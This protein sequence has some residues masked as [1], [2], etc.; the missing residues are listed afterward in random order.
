MTIEKVRIIKTLKCGN[1]T[2]WVGQVYPQ[3]DEPIPP[4]IMREVENH[5]GTVEV[6]SE[7]GS[8]PDEKPEASETEAP[9]KLIV[10]GK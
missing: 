5:A 3:G 6:L 9:R 7:S 10:R 4:D 2:Y 8:V 1:T